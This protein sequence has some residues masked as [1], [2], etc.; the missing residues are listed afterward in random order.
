MCRLNHLRRKFLRDEK[1]KT[2]YVRFMEDILEKG[3]AETVQQSDYTGE[4]M[5]YIREIPDQA[6]F[7]ETVQ[8]LTWLDKLWGFLSLALC[9]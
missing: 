8:T 1:Y 2:D 7:R 3:D 4:R 6:T 5:W 9:N